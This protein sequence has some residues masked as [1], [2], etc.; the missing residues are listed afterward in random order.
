[1]GDYPL[2]WNLGFGG[3]CF[4]GACVDS[5]LARLWGYPFVFYP[6]RAGGGG[7]LEVLAVGL[8]YLALHFAISI[9]Y[10]YPLLLRA[11]CCLPLSFFLFYFCPFFL[12]PIFYFSF[13]LFHSTSR[14]A[15][16]LSLPLLPIAL[17]LP[18]PL[19]CSLFLPFAPARFFARGIF[20]LLLGIWVRGVMRHW[21]KYALDFKRVA[22][23]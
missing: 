8:G 20:W 14:C 17:L 6:P 15:T 7:G 19:F 12:P 4:F 18:F 10:F 11:G 2:F 23:V 22:R 9:G 16:S 21:L 3:S 5:P 1:M 13:S